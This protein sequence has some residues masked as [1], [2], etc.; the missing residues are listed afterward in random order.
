MKIKKTAPIIVTGALLA[1]GLSAT[2]YAQGQS[3]NKTPTATPP[4]MGMMQGK[5]GAHHDTM[6]ANMKAGD[7]KLGA[8]AGKMNVAKGN[9]KVEAMA[10]VINEM[11][12]QRKMMHSQIQTMHERTMGGG[13]MSGGK[14]GGMMGGGMMGKTSTKPN[15]KMG[16]MHDKMGAHHDKMVANMKT[17]D[18]RLNKL[19]T[20]MNAA[21][22]NAKI[23]AIAAVIN[24][25]VAQHKMMF[26]QMHT[27][28][29]KMMGGG[30]MGGSKSGNKM[31][32]GMMGGSKPGGMMGKP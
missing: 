24:E 16:M 19:V 27:M 28:N 21:K 13:M 25:M 31:G 5:M 26:S 6:M 1:S 18:A 22:G 29:E 14:S 8:L 32:G 10:A 20:M 9:A 30:M 15:A 23:S 4:K 17:N 2:L 3:S 12:A 11:V 7:A